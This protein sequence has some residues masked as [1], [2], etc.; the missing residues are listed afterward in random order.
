VVAATRE[1]EGTLPFELLGF[2]TDSGSE[3]LN[4]PK[5]GRK[6]WSIFDFVDWC[7]D[8]DVPGA[9]LASYFFP[10]DVNEAWL[11]E[12]KRHCYLRGV[13]IAGT[14]VGNNFALPK[15]DKLNEEIAYTKMDRP[16]RHHGRTAHPR[17]C[18]PA[19]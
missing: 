8:H 17:V 14:A 9:E 3:F 2:D 11:L 18:R 19:A 10:P 1:V 6:P 5:D 15:G 13:Q 7:A 16:F 12:L 4:W